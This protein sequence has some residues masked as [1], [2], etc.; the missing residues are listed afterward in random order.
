MYGE[1]TP[2]IHRHVVGVCVCVCVSEQKGK[3]SFS[4]GGGLGDRMA[5]HSQ[6]GKPS[7]STG[8]GRGCRKKQSTK[9][10]WWGKGMPQKQRDILF[11]RA[12]PQEGYPVPQGGGGAGRI[13]HDIHYLLKYKST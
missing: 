12:K 1:R 11:H 4:T 7:C 2:Y 5:I 6:R 13:H 9:P 8:G 10:R 3:P